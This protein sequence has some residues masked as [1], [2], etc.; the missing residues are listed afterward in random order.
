MRVN[1]ANK[2]VCI[3]GM[4]IQLR[5]EASRRVT[6][7]AFMAYTLSTRPVLLPRYSNMRNPLDNDCQRVFS[8][9]YLC[10]FHISSPA[11]YGKKVFNTF[12]MLCESLVVVTKSGSTSSGSMSGCEYHTEKI[13]PYLNRLFLPST[14]DNRAVGLR[15][16]IQTRSLSGVLRY[17]SAAQFHRHLNRFPASRRPRSSVPLCQTELHG[18]GGRVH[19]PNVLSIVAGSGLPNIS[20]VVVASLLARGVVVVWFVVVSSAA[21]SSSETMSFNGR[22]CAAAALSSRCRTVSGIQHNSCAFPFWV[23]LTRRRALACR[24]YSRIL[25]TRS[26]SSIRAAISAY[27]CLESAYHSN[28]S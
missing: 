15:R 25:R 3:A 18:R 13:R 16:K 23:S 9:L 27:L 28:K 7:A 10:V 11:D 26:A 8:F 20:S 12:A 4:A 14:S 5:S 1:L 19:P 22:D 17:S 2:G 21:D 24:L 6:S